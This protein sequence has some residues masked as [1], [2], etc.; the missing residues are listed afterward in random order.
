[1]YNIE[2]LKKQYPPYSGKS[3][4]NFI[5]LTGRKFGN[6]LVLYRTLDKITTGGNKKIQWVCKCQCENHTIVVK[7][8]TGLRNGSIVGCGCTKGNRT[9]E[10]LPGTKFGNWEVIK[11]VPNHKNNQ[12]YY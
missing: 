7:S 3:S 9:K 2:E 11:R 6:L 10:V 12:V 1:M 4:K 5:D 8:G